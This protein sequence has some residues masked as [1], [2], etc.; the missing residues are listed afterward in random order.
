M[1]VRRV[2][3]SAVKAATRSAISSSSPSANSSTR[4]DGTQTDS[5]DS[6]RGI[7]SVGDAKC[8]SI[9]KKPGRET[10]SRTALRYY[11]GARRPST[12]CP[13]LMNRR[14]WSVIDSQRRADAGHAG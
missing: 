7:A 5:C 4:A 3:L 12:S 13:S 8:R 6:G 10:F 14:G 11:P 2:R 9:D 1:R